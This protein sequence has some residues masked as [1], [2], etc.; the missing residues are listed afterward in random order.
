MSRTLN[1]LSFTASM[2]YLIVTVVL[3]QQVLTK[4]EATEF[5]WFYFYFMI[6]IWMLAA[7][8]QAVI[9]DKRMHTEVEKYLKKAGFKWDRT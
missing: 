4:I 2:V 6:A 8:A 9:S 5:M 3:F 7:G 1:V